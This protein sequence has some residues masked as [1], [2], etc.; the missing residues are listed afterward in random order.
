VLATSAIGPRGH[1]SSGSVGDSF[2]NRWN[3]AGNR[4]LFRLAS[5]RVRQRWRPTLIPGTR[6]GGWPGARSRSREPR[7]RRRVRAGGGLLRVDCR[8]HIHARAHRRSHRPLQP[9]GQRV[10]SPSPRGR[11]RA[12]RAAKAGGAVQPRPLPRPSKASTAVSTTSRSTTATCT[13]PGVPPPRSCCWCRCTC[14]AW[15]RRPA[16]PFH[17]SRSSGWALRSRRFARYCVS[18]RAFRC[19]CACS[20]RRRSR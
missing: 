4:T 6:A 20:R 12:R 16:S 13:S 11:S 3:Y 14:S 15:N 19:G 5:A 7:P 9:A 2:I 8:Y 17:C 18:S 10:P 1:R